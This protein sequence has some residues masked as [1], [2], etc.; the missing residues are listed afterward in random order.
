MELVPVEFSIPVSTAGVQLKQPRVVDNR[1]G[2][3]LKGIPRNITSPPS[4]AP[5]GPVSANSHC[6][7]SDSHK[8]CWNEDVRPLDRG[9]LVDIYGHLTLTRGVVVNGRPPR[10]DKVSSGL[11]R[12]RPS[13]GNNGTF[14]PS[15]QLVTSKPRWD[16]SATPAF[17]L[18]QREFRAV[19]SNAK[20]LIPLSLRDQRYKGEV[21]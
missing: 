18:E 12:T 5:K 20:R 21:K 8:T 13:H 10:C 17:V 4:K 2:A 19:P 9:M 1:A 15:P 16:A 11:R 14:N 6:N 3:L 7:L